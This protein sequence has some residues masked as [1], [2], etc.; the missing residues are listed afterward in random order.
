MTS[1]VDLA[2][3]APEILVAVTMLV[4]LTVDLFLDDR[5]RHLSAYLTA[6][7]LAGAGVLAWRIGS[8]GFPASD[9][10][11][12]MLVWDPFG[13]FFKLLFIASTLLVLLFSVRSSEVDPKRVGEFQVFMLAILLGICF[14]ATGRHLVML[15]LSVELVSITSYILTGYIQGNR[16]SAEGAFKYVVYGGVATGVMIFGMSLLYGLTGTADLAEIGRALSGPGAPSGFSVFVIFLLVLAGIGFKMAMVPFHMW[17][18]DVYQ[19]A[20]TPV[21]AFLSVGP[22]LAGFALLMRFLATAAS[23]GTGSGLAAAWGALPSI[24]WPVLLGV[25]SVLTMT[26]GNLSALGQT[27]LKRMLAYS[28]IAHAGYLLMGCVVGSALG[29]RAVLFYGVV[30]VVMNL[31]A[32]F[33]VILVADRVGSDDVRDYEGLGWKAPFLGVA[34]AVFLFS[35]TGLPPTGGFVAKFYLFASVLAGGGWFYLLALLGLLNGVVSLYYYVSVIRA[36]FLRS[37]R[38]DAPA[39]PVSLPHRLVLG[40]LA[41]LTVVLGLFWQPVLNVTEEVVSDFA[42]T[43]SFRAAR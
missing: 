40:G 41:A 18:P 19:G 2:F 42:R 35:L 3:I 25:L 5:H 28:S 9:L 38:S 34:L 33:V 14:M 32:F 16:A 12:G 29:Y 8:R 4:V 21:T 36:M 23:E 7:G 43:T 27:S 6:L 39:V 20:P 1:L 10:F 31:G 15:Y 13:N 37:A 17:C 24:D 30:Y 26:V 11:S 22:K